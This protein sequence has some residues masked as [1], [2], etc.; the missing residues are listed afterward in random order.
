MWNQTR[1]FRT[2]NVKYLEETL[3]YQ[4]RLMR[5]RDLL[6]RGGAPLCLLI[7]PV[8][9][10]YAGAAVGRAAKP[11]LDKYGGSPRLWGRRQ[12]NGLVDEM[13]R[14]DGSNA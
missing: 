11:W 14:G 13:Y 7:M 9:G 8:L 5:L 6:P 10:G 4:K 12:E 3:S 2:R 1:W